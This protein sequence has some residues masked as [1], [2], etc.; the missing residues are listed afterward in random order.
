MARLTSCNSVQIGSV[1]RNECT[2]L[3]RPF[4]MGMDRPGFGGRRHEA[5]RQRRLLRLLR[6]RA[7]RDE[8]DP[9]SRL[10]FE[11]LVPIISLP[12]HSCRL[13]CRCRP[14]AIMGQ[15]GQPQAT[16]QCLASSA[17]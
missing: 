6:T 5:V 3:L 11:S 14:A 10:Y 8:S 9:W 7:V 15:H 4:G 12:V 13:N 17:S 1:Q 2:G 16:N